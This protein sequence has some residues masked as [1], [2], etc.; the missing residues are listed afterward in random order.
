V[1]AL[2]SRWAGTA[3]RS[4]RAAFALACGLGLAYAASWAG[5][6]PARAAQRP[7]WWIADRDAH[8]L[9]GLDRDLHVAARR[10]LRW[11]V[12][13]AARADGGTW[14]ARALEDGPRGAHELAC[15]D[16]SARLRA[17]FA[18]S[19]VHALCA[20]DGEVLYALSEEPGAPAQLLRVEL[21]AG[22]RALAPFAGARWLC[23]RS[24]GELVIGAS[25]G[26]LWSV[27]G[28]GVVHA[29]QQL[30]AELAAL[31]PGPREGTC[32]VLERAPDARL[33]LLGARLEPLRVRRTGLTGGELAAERGSERVWV[34]DARRKHVRRFGP[35]G[36]LELDRTDV[37][38]AGITAGA[39]LRGGGA[40]WLAPGAL[41]R[42]DARGELAPGQG[43]FGHAHDLARV[44]DGVGAR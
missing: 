35:A 12:L 38:L 29:E 23:A 30:G 5:P 18:A 41:L 43:G 3:R 16:A 17:R 27:D 10:E 31:A 33:W 21:E 42:V 4:L 44:P 32:W 26:R 15:F 22:P 2:E 8:Q 13:L 40:L 6:V 19:P 24:A 25:D 7:A 34:A 1:G 37:P 36:Q 9:V 11:P 20:P 39:A 14:V 28:A